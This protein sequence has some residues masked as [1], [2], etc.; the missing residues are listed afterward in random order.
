MVEI[1]IVFRFFREQIGIEWQIMVP[2]TKESETEKDYP[3]LDGKRIDY[4]FAFV[5]FLSF[6]FA[7]S[8]NCHLFGKN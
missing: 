2:G 8:E 5:S 1:S 7:P 6:S 4:N 3:D